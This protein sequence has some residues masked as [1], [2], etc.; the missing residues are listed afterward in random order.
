ML[1]AFGWGNRGVTAGHKDEPGMD[2]PS[3]TETSFESAHPGR[4]KII[5]LWPKC[6]LEAKV[7]L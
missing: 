1:Q 6:L 4:I 7:N 5:Y 2:Q 3:Q